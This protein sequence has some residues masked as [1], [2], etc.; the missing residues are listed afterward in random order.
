MYAH[1]LFKSD[2]PST[3]PLLCSQPR[4][5]TIPFGMKMVDLFRE[6]TRTQKGW[7]ILPDPV[8]PAMQSFEQMPLDDGGFGLEMAGLETVYMYLR[9]GK[10][11]KI[12]KEW[13]QFFPKAA[14]TV[15]SRPK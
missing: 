15:A 13:K 6:F 4:E 8:P 7:T 5:Y 1:G 2:N 10:H 12:P 9:L 14:P 3:L 11:L